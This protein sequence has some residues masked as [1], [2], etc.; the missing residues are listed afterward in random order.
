MNV[1]SGLRL[2]LVE[3]NPG[4]AELTRER[5]VDGRD[6]QVVAVVSLHAA[7]DCLA[8]NTIDG[9]LLDLNLPDSQGLASLE[10]MHAAF[11]AI[12]V[13][14]LSGGIDEELRARCRRAGAVEVFGKAETASQLFARAL[15]YAIERSRAEQRQLQISALVETQPDAIVIVN[16]EGAVRYVNRATLELFACSKEE[17]LSE[18]LG[19]SVVAGVTVELLILRRDGPRT[20]EVRVVPIDWY[21]EP[22][23]LASLRDV[24][25][26]KQA[27]ERSREL[28]RQNLR[29][30]AAKEA[31]ER[32]SRHK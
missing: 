21:N 1:T 5:I 13:V 20:A 16:A 26:R 10:R 14:V 28:E 31:I 3:D 9:V 17:L 22:C 8:L 24:T 25:W 32:E 4:D 19:F 30:Q 6:V 15:L 23:L 2:L 11:P 7:L 27:E 29:I 18:R 12:P